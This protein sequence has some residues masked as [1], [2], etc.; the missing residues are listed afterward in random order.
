MMQK[1]GCNIGNDMRDA[2]NESG[3]RSPAERVQGGPPTPQL[4]EATSIKSVS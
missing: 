2:Q 1:E 4:Q 3:Y